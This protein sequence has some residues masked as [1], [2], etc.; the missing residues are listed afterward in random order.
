MY[1][2]AFADW[3]ISRKGQVIWDIYALHVPD[4]T[5]KYL[6]TVHPEWIRFRGAC[7]YYDLPELLKDYDVGVVIYKG[8]IPNYVY[9]APNKVMEYAACGLD[10][11]YARE[12][13]G[14]HPYDTP[15]T[16]YPR[17][18]RLDFTN[19]A[20][21][22]MDAALDRSGKHFSPAPYNCEEALQPLLTA[23]RESGQ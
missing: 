13:I 16:V 17:I 22:D 4:E 1:V 2:Q 20:A 23:I 19:M 21:F 18:I 7:Y 11:W 6:Q 10:V 14:T 9:N 5:R 8:L 12:L 3:V 15:E